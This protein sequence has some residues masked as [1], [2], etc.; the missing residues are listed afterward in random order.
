MIKLKADNSRITRNLGKKYRLVPYLEKAISE[1]DGEWQYSYKEKGNDHHWHPSSHCTLTPSQLFAV[2]T[3][4]YESEPWPT[5]TLKAFQV[6]HFWH[7]W[8]QYIVEHSLHFAT[9]EEIERH[10]VHSWGYS[11][12]EKETPISSATWKPKPYHSVAGSA[13]IAPCTTP[14]WSGGVDF[15]T[16]NVRDFALAEK[17]VL[18]Q[19][20][21]DKYECQL[22]LYMDLF[23][24]DEWLLVAVQKESPH[25][26]AEILYRRNQPLIDHL[27]DKFKYVTDAIDAGEAISTLEDDEWPK[28]PLAGPTAF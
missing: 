1:F 19:Y 25:N 3:E 10:A 7:Q 15:K 6:G 16:M 24:E 23:D 5:S 26:F 12:D 8:L 18:S 27:Y 20:N 28:M 4:T 13:D 22:N 11:L 21:A 17:Q 9:A 2:A 14:N